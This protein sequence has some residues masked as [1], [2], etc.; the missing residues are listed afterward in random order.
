[1]FKIISDKSNG[2]KRS[3]PF[4]IF[5][6]HDSVDKIIIQKYHPV[7]GHCCEAKETLWKQE[8]VSSSSSLRGHEVTFSDND[9]VNF[10]AAEVGVDILKFGDYM[11]LIMVIVEEMALFTA[12][13]TEAM[14]VVGRLMGTRDVTM[15]EMASRKSINQTA[16]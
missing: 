15:L 9:M 4:I 3:S 1:M 6:D 10:K 13:V 16:R 8:M 2:G 7:D 5:D 14:A 11:D 12:E